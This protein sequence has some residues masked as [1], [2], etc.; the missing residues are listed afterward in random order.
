MDKKIILFSLL[1][2]IMLCHGVYGQE[3]PD[4]TRQKTITLASTSPDAFALPDNPVKFSPAAPKPP[5][6]QFLTLKHDSLQHA[7]MNL[8]FTVN[9]GPLPSTIAVI[10]LGLVT[11]VIMR[12][13]R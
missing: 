5:Y 13:R 6:N 4:I 1:I 10:L 7:G 3:H 2:G 12:P 9:A 8:F 11:A